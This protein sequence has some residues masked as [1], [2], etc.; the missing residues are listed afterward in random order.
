MNLGFLITLLLLTLVSYFL[1]NGGL[2]FS[3]SISKPDTIKTLNKE[4][5]NFELSAKSIL[6]HNT[7]IYRFALPN[8][9]GVLGIPI[10]Q[11]IT[12]SGNINGKEILRSYT[13][14]SLDSD[15]VG[16]F[17]ILIKAYEKG[18]I[19]KMISELQIGDF[20]KVKGPKGF[21]NYEP[22][23]LQSIGMVAG[24]TGIS[25]MYQII[26][27][28]FNNPNDR[29]K[30]TLIYG[31][32]SIT[33]ISLK[34][35]LDSIVKSKPNQFKVI[36]I[37]DKVDEGKPWDGE[38][39]YVTTQIMAENLPGPSKSSQ[40]LICGPPPMVSSVKRNAVALGFQKPGIIS[41][42]GDQ[43]FVF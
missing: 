3:K 13:P 32:Q 1:I 2:N 25:P 9:N 40:L 16:Y 41:K 42:M 10:G 5:Q 33:D 14:I 20:I 29:S 39:G 6:T 23:I 38:V 19:S 12:I 22:N 30:V 4:W 15:S 18:K 35:E 8:P 43:V 27:A 28:I 26:K 7:A 37:V 21:Y 31:N 34:K 17:D 36:Y 24:G 11:H